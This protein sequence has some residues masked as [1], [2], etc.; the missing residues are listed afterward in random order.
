MNQITLLAKNHKD[1]FVDALTE[2]PLT[3]HVEKNFSM[4]RCI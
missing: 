1:F 2:Q 3:F 4:N